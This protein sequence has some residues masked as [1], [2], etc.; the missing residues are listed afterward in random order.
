MPVLCR[1]TS[2]RQRVSRVSRLE[3]TTIWPS[4]RPQPYLPTRRR[5]TAVLR[6]LRNYAVNDN[7]I[8][9]LV[10][11]CVIDLTLRQLDSR[12][13]V[14]DRALHLD[15]AL[16]LVND[17]KVIG[18]LQLLDLRR[19]LRAIVGDR[20]GYRVSFDDSS[21]LRIGEIPLSATFPKPSIVSEEFVAVFGENAP[22]RCAS[23]GIRPT[24]GSPDR[25]RSLWAYEHRFNAPWAGA[26]A[27]F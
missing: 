14:T 25:R 11:F 24:N 13:A 23:C 3:R 7:E 19:A 21:L 5:N 18:L 22:S 2:S 1:F 17:P 12:H 15:M 6:P 8:C 4:F 27:G 10:A 9:R 16:R 20:L 26:S